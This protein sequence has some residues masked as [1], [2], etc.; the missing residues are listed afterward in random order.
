MLSVH[1]TVVMSLPPEYQLLDD[2]NFWQSVDRLASA[3]SP[4]FVRAV[5]LGA[6]TTDVGPGGVAMS[7]YTPVFEAMKQIGS[8]AATML[9]ARL[10]MSDAILNDSALLAF[11]ETFH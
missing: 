7:S 1:A 6:R 8:A 9:D 2:E 5:Q 10:D 11:S 3:F 4:S